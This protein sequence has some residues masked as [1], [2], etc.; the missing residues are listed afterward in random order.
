MTWLNSL[1]LWDDWNN[2]RSMFSSLFKSL[3]LVSDSNGKN[4][5][6]YT[7]AA[8]Y[9]K[10]IHVIIM[11]LNCWKWSSFY[12][13]GTDNQH[14]QWDG[15]KKRLISSSHVKWLLLVKNTLAGLLIFHNAFSRRNR[16]LSKH[17]PFK[18][19]DGTNNRTI[20]LVWLGERAG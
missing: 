14:H 4:I 11:L 19:H 3:E 8:F 1:S 6:S 15:M 9:Y 12:Y 10:Q 7:R 5:I 13:Y 20:S 16:H 17:C 18:V 2:K